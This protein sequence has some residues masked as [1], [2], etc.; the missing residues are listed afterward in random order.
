MVGS[1]AANSGTLALT[2]AHADGGGSLTIN[3]GGTVT[4]NTSNTAGGNFSALGGGGVILSGGTLANANLGGSAATGETPQT[5]NYQSGGMLTLTSGTTSYLD[6][7][8]GN[9]GGV[10]N[11]SSLAIAGSAPGTLLDIL[12]YK[13]NFTDGTNGGDGIRPVVHRGRLADGCAGRHSVPQPLGLQRDGF[14][15]SAH[16]R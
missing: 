8:L 5:N 3:G 2:A 11:F 10:F 12:N 6:F 16:G 9:T 4:L 7:G 13:G 1:G 14:C 15:G